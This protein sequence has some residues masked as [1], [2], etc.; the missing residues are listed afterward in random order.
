MNPSILKDLRELV[1]ANVISEST[2]LSIQE[3]YKAK[4]KDSNSFTIIL[5]IIGSILV[6][7]GIVL[8]IAHNWDDFGRIIK[9]IFAFLPLI[10]SQVL[11]FYVIRRKMDSIAWKE[12]AAVFLFF[13]VGTCISLISQ[14]Y[15]ISGS[16]AGY[17][18]TWM[19]LTLPLIYIFSS[20]VVSLLYVG[21][22]TWYG[23]VV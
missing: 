20:F 17:L 4:K 7:L 23:A 6:A 21:G 16:L 2:S 1:E 14:I 11:C 22:I 19:L 13:S 8:V 9:T 5:S 18:F 10:L 12:S 3:F 15:H